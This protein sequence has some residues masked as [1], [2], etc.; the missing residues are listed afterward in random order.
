MNKAQRGHAR[1]DGAQGLGHSHG[2]SDGVGMRRGCQ[3]VNEVR[4]AAEDDESAE[5]RKEFIERM[6]ISEQSR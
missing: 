1:H 2:N 5:L 6:L 3:E 4:R